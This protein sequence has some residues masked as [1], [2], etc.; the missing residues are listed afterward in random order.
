MKTLSLSKL[1]I[2]APTTRIQ[3]IH[4]TCLRISGIHTTFPQFKRRS[5]SK[6]RHREEKEAKNKELE[7]QLESA[8]EW[9]D[10]KNSSQPTVIR[11]KRAMLLEETDPFE[12]DSLTQKLKDTIDRLRKDGSS[13]KQ[14]RS[15]P[16]LIRGLHVE[17]P[18]DLGGRLPFLEVANVGPKP[19]DARSLLITVFDVQ[20]SNHGIRELMVVYKTYC[21]SHCSNLSEFK[22][23]TCSEE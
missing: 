14:G 15:D 6:A 22:S 1:L 9:L 20:V 23:S 5:D 13:I 17:L 3:F 8:E 19:G 18:S 11:G 21:T 16:E 7:A 10:S 4:P 2:S 12:M